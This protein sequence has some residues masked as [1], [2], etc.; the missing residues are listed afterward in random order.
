MILEKFKIKKKCYVT[1]EAEVV[2]LDSESLLNTGSAGDIPWD[3]EGEEEQTAKKISPSL[4]YDPT[5][6][7][8]EEC[9]DE[10]LW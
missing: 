4:T 8:E 3:P 10:Y 7:M 6:G 9:D 2:L 1:P 5:W